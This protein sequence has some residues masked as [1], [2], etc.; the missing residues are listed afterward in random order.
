MSAE[1]QSSEAGRWFS[2]ANS[3]V[4]AARDSLAAGR[5]EWACFQA[6]QA[7][8]KAMKAC[9][10]HL[11]LE[12]WGHSVAKLVDE[13]PEALV[14]HRFRCLKETA[15]DLDKLHVPTRYPNGL[16]GITPA[17]AFSAGNATEAINSAEGILS[18]ARA[19]LGRSTPN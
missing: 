4:A 16:P 17:E 11:D 14:E 13:L 19:L 9:W 7:A 5:Y 3:D 8:E 6:Q 12:P 18:A 10:F 2:Q 15:R 1:K